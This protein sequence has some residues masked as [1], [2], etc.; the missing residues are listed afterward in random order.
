MNLWPEKH[1][2]CLGPAPEAD[3]LCLPLRGLEEAGHR[4]RLPM[5]ENLSARYRKVQE[6]KDQI[7]VMV[8]GVHGNQQ[9]YYV[10]KPREQTKAQVMANPSTG[11][12]I[13]KLAKRNKS[14]TGKWG[15]RGAGVENSGRAR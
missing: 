11:Q 13:R 8:S 12:K 1:V 4:I 14:G 3:T 2:F 15:A 10:V 5:A 9:Q 7:R 6:M